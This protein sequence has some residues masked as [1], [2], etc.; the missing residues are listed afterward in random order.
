MNCT[1]DCGGI[2]TGMSCGSTYGGGTL[3]IIVYTESSPA[4]TG[5]QL[6]GDVA[7]YYEA[8]MDNSCPGDITNLDCVL[9]RIIHA[10]TQIIYSIQ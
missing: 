8:G 6:F 4:Y 9:Q 7:G 5:G 1:L 3:F 2:E 10:D